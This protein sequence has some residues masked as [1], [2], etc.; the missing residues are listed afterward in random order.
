[1]KSVPHG[2]G[3]HE[4][5]VVK[6]KYKEVAPTWELTIEKYVYGDKQHA[7]D[8]DYEHVESSKH[9]EYER[10]DGQCYY[11]SL[12]EPKDKG[13]GYQGARPGP[14]TWRDCVWRQKVHHLRLNFS[15]KVS[16]LQIH[17]LRRA[18]FFRPRANVCFLCLDQ[19]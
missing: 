7:Y 13:Q 18:E 15:T 8:P 4:G 17:M 2:L 9:R 6:T 10:L 1:M 12:K 5:V 11:E 14:K 3:K 19:I 16:D